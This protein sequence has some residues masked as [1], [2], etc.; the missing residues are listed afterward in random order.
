MANDANTFN[1]RTRRRRAQERLVRESEAACKAP[2]VDRY[3]CGNCGCVVHV[4]PQQCP[5]CGMQ[6]APWMKI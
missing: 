6:I 1:E 5:Y 4:K 3:R 2:E